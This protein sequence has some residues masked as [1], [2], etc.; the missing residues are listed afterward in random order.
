MSSAAAAEIGIEDGL[1]AMSLAGCLPFVLW[2][3]QPKLIA[4][5]KQTAALLKLIADH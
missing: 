5:A 2:Q 3:Q 1:Q 4:A